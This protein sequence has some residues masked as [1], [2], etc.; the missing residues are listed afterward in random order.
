MIQVQLKIPA[1]YSG[2]IEIFHFCVAGCFY[3]STCPMKWMDGCSYYR[4]EWVC[5]VLQTGV[6]RGE[7]H[8]L[9]GFLK[10]DGSGS[11]CDFMAACPGVYSVWGEPSRVLHQ[12]GFKCSGR[13]VY[14][15]NTSFSQFRG[16]L[17]ASRI[18]WNV[19]IFLFFVNFSSKSFKD[20][21]PI[22]IF[23]RERCFVF[24]L[25]ELNPEHFRPQGL[26]QHWASTCGVSWPA[27]ASP[28][29]C[30]GQ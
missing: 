13:V 8:W 3:I 15:V 21:K 6:L 7:L 26:A 23:I 30:R 9:V 16:I 18:C 27:V 14:L 5:K 11:A 29:Y 22:T 10:A 12:K 4:C 25:E 24:L 17:W 20:L 28:L 19:F 1:K 2:S